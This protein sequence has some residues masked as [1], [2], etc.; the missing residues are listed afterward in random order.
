MPRNREKAYNVKKMN[1]GIF[2]ESQSMDVLGSLLTMAND[3]K[4]SDSQHTF[5]RSIQTHPNPLSLV[6]GTTTQFQN[7]KAY[8]T[9]ELVSSVLTVDPTFIISK[10]SVTPITHQDLLLVSKR[11]GAHPICIGPILISQN[12]TKD[13]Y[14]DFV[15]F[16][17][18]NCP[19][20][21][22]DLRAF[23]T[24]GEKPPE[25]SF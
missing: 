14:A 6:S 3:E 25:Q 10:Y 16:I 20:L 15:Y 1:A 8:C 2:Q 12:L 18:K 13:V 24:V 22:H 7:L 5:I 23:E 19:G 9:S 4:W 21:K 17:Q 11:T